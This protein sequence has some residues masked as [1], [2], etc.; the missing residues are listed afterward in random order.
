MSLEPGTGTG[1]LAIIL[2]KR[3]I[4]QI[5]ATDVNPRALTC[6]QDNFERQGLAHVHL[7]QVD[8]FPTDAPLANLIVCNPPW[9]PANPTSP[10]EYSVYDANS[11]MLKG[12]YRAQ[13]RT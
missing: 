4:K 12:F 8:L 10:L 1:L 2:A 3:G 13:N 6:A 9:L 7:Q 5:I 11:A